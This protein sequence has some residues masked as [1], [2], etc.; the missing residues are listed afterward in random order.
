MDNHQR[1]L[2]SKNKILE[3]DRQ[4]VVIGTLSEKTLHAILKNYLESDEDKQEI[5]I[6]K[7][8]ADIYNGKEIIEIQ[9][10]QFNRLR[11]KL[12]SFLPEYKV[13]IVYPI[14][15]VKWLLWVDDETGEVSNKRKSPKVGNELLIFP[16]LYKI[17]EF[18][19]H[20]NLYFKIILLDLE[21]YKL[22]NGYGKQKK[23]RASKYDRIPISIF[24]EIDI[25]RI[26]DY[27]QFIPYEIK[28]PFTV[29][30]YAKECKINVNL[31]GVTLN[32]LYH[33]SVV[34]RIGKEGNAYLYRVR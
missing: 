24:K 2:D 31:A 30:D 16:E 6:N 21:E 11:D 27:L 4:K 19:T 15:H 25:E 3:K 10:S 34:E 33:L 29:K 8:V 26:E 28:E 20:Q 22:L 5:P 12:K 13:T 18:L 7:Y 32:I 14:A 9:T 17:K 1:F 23:I